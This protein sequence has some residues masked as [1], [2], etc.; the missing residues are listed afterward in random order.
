MISLSEHKI[1]ITWAEFISWKEEK[2]AK[3][4]EDLGVYEFYVGVN[5]KKRRIYVGKADNLKV[6]YKQHLSDDEPNQCLK[7][8]LKKN[9]WYYRYAIIKDKADREDAEL[10]LYRKYSYECNKIEPPGSGRKSF[11]IVEDP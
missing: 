7:K 8:H 10:G 2:T 4:P 9:V 1:K 3:I 11:T 6:I 5:G